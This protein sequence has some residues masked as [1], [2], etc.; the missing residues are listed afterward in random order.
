MLAL[1]AVMVV[2]V[3]GFSAIGGPEHGLIDA[4]YMT[5]ITLTTVGFGEIIDMSAN[6]A[7]RLFTVGLLL[8]GMGIVAY[9]LSQV[10]AFVVE[11]ELLHI[12]ERRRMQRTLGR[13]SGHYVVCGDT[14]AAWYVAEELMRTGRQVAI[15]AATEEV[16]AEADE[17]LGQPPGI[18]G[19]PDDD[20]VLQE[21][22]IE[23]AAGV[24]FCSHND[25]DNV[26]G[27]LTAR[28]L[29]P[30]ARII[31]ATE[32]PETESKL[33]SAGADAVVSPSRIGG[34]RMAS[35]LVRPGV[36]SF[37]DQMLRSERSSLRVEEVTVP[38]GA[39][40]VGKPLGFLEVDT[41]PGVLLI[42]VRRGAG[43]DFEFKPSPE[44]RVEAG[45]TL[46][47][48]AD[49]KARVRLEELVSRK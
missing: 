33:L 7:G 48:M 24:V 22:G 4:I 26:L 2:G 10:T 20:G 40:A 39:A 14:P 30:A 41:L 49:A 1:L 23:R 16:L 8:V 15:V 44:V 42:A 35:E 19:D 38:S 46:V 36:V 11:G 6:P 28:R 17:R 34:L 31:A 47:V 45:M 43:G 12:F 25:K 5:T 29:A 9:A 21:A 13:L 27:V 32:R 18:A 37:L 3:V